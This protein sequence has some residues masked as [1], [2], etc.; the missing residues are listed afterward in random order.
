VKRAD[1][2]D[3]LMLTA[4]R[5]AAG[6]ARAFAE[7]ALEK[8]AAPT[9]ADDVAVIVS[10]LVTNAVEAAGAVSDDPGG[11]GGRIVVRLLGAEDGLVIEVWDAAP[12]KPLPAGSGDP[13]AEG[14]RGLLLVEALSSGW[15]W[16]ATPY[17][18]TVWARV[19]VVGGAAAL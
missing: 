7:L 4:V 11:L 3:Q 6:H 16:Y 2:C 13:D 1:S 18:K 8:W 12:G 9:P 15:G 14:G 10:E 19:A 17:G 5:T